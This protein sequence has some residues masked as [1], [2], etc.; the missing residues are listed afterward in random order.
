MEPKE[1]GK[2]EKNF[3]SFG[4]KVDEFMLELNEAGEKLR[5]E[6]EMKFE[7]LKATAEKLK[8]EAESNERWREVESSLKKAGDELS[9][10]FKAAFKKR[11]P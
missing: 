7:E 3:K 6:F 2:N 4:K 9:T 8:K 5:K 10:A 1:A 11:N